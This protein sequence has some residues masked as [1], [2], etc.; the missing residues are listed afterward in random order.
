MRD[1]SELPPN[2]PSAAGE[3]SGRPRV[4][5]PRARQSPDALQPRSERSL[6]AAAGGRRGDGAVRG[7]SPASPGRGALGPKARAR[8]SRSR[9]RDSP[10]PSEISSET[11]ATRPLSS[12]PRGGCKRARVAAGTA[13]AE[14]KRG[15]ARRKC[16]GAQSV[17]STSTRRSAR[18]GPSQVRPPL[19][20]PRPTTAPLLPLHFVP[21]RPSLP[22]PPPHADHTIQRL[23]SRSV[24]ALVPTDRPTDLRPSSPPAEP[25]HDAALRACRRRPP[26]PVA[27]PRPPLSPALHPPPPWARRP[28]SARTLDGLLGS[29]EAEAD[30]LVEAEAALAGG[31]AER[32]VVAARGAENGKRGGR[33]VRRRRMV[34]G[35]GGRGEPR[36]A[37]AARSAVSPSRSLSRRPGQKPRAVDARPGARAAAP[38]R[39]ARRTGRRGLADDA[40]PEAE[41]R[42]RA[43]R[44][45]ASGKNARS[46]RGKGWW[47]DERVS[48]R[49]RSPSVQ[50]AARPPR[51]RPAPSPAVRESCARRAAGAVSSPGPPSCRSRESSKQA[52]RSERGLGGARGVPSTRR[53]PRGR[54]PRRPAPREWRERPIR[55]PPTGPAARAR[56]R[57]ERSPGRGRRDAPGEGARGAEARR[58][59]AR[60]PRKGAPRALWRRSTVRRGAGGLPRGHRRGPASPP[61]PSPPRFR[62]SSP[63]RRL[64]ARAPAWGR[65]RDVRIAGLW[66]RSPS[67]VRGARVDASHSRRVLASARRCVGA[68]ARGR[69]AG[70]VRGRAHPAAVGARGAGRGRIRRPPG[71]RPLAGDP[72]AAPPEPAAGGRAG[73]ARDSGVLGRAPSRAGRRKSRGGEG[74]GGDGRRGGAACPRA[75]VGPLARSVPGLAGAGG[76]VGRVAADAISGRRGARGRGPRGGR[77]RREGRGPPLGR[78]RRSEAGGVRR[79]H[80]AARARRR[81]RQGRSDRTGA[82]RVDLDGARRRTRPRSRSARFC[83]GQTS[84]P[85]PGLLGPLPCSPF[86]L[87]NS[88]LSPAPLSHSNRLLWAAPGAPLRT[89]SR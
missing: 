27:H 76:R 55:A 54:R 58:G 59:T 18:D 80:R 78:G 75:P 42:T 61:L 22:F 10:R 24:H 51:P 32:L 9:T 86:S 64:S 36:A 23:L 82:D 15:R 41:M 25:C 85:R 12:A 21:Q 84:Q 53:A 48:R 2:R 62:P 7:H 39:Q 44:P 14:R 77:R 46:A 35:G 43:G 31:L 60:R 88:P 83:E 50:R 52:R 29:L 47:E 74:R 3:I 8:S 40:P 38:R 34:A 73:R 63:S 4:S 5:G 70:A 49:Q 17:R 67:R 65:G 87:P 66:A 56:A 69:D 57:P 1:A 33:G 19:L 6:R 16:L 26:S 45:A 28:A 13:K 37:G 30:R 89:R 72:A 20:W 79:G 71:C 81:S 11:Q 68:V